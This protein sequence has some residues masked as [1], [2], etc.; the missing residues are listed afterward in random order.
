MRSDHRRGAGRPGPPVRGARGAQG[1]E[2]RPLRCGA[3]ALAATCL[4]AGPLEAQGGDTPRLDRGRFELR[5]GGERTGT[6]SFEIRR[7]GQNVKAVAQISGTGGASG[8]RQVMIQT[9]TD[10]RPE[11]FR[12][13][14]E[15]AD[16]RRVTAVREEGRLRLQVSSLQGDRWKEFLAP[17]DLTLVQPDVAHLWYLVLRQHRQGLESTG[18]VRVPAVVPSEA[19]RAELTIRREGREQ[20]ST[21]GAD[22]PAVR[23]TA[24][25]DDG[26][27][28]RIWTSEEGTVLRVEIPGRGWSAVRLP[29]AG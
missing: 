1:P 18:R 12:L 4:L 24:T 6:E 2:R 3:A 15:G 27:E 26:T 28:V 19:R 23:Y 10:F 8:A 5:S 14:P 21:P 22:R 11:L 25:L 16:A 29:E 13:R 20:V 17:A 7:T 9:G